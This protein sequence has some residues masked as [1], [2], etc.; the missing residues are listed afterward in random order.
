M[1]N[2]VKHV[3]RL[4]CCTV[5]PRD[6]S[7]PQGSCLSCTGLSSSWKREKLVHRKGRGHSQAQRPSSWHEESKIVGTLS[8]M[9]PE[10]VSEDEFHSFLVD[11]WGAGLTIQ[12][13][14]SGTQMFRIDNWYGA[15]SDVAGHD[16]PS[17]PLTP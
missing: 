1:G 15:F 7:S 17:L 16:P 14:A 12:E 13:W 8:Y 11:V 2:L 9:S 4:G 6:Q 5:A 3:E 10:I